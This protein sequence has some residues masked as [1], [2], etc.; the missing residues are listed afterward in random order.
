MRQ[1]LCVALV[2]LAVSAGCRPGNEPAVQPTPEKP[3]AAADDLAAARKEFVT[4]LRVRGPAPQPFR[5]A[6]PPAG[7]KEVEFA[8]G[9]LT[10]LAP[11]PFDPSLHRFNEGACDAAGR[12]WI[13]VGIATHENRP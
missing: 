2:F 9:D 11:P 5:N 4:K 12:F 1:S 8:S 10:P 13:G 6:K 3:A 7:V